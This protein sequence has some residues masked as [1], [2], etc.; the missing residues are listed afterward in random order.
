MSLEIGQ[1]VH[2][3]IGKQSYTISKVIGEGGQGTVYLLKNNYEMLALKWY[4][5]EQATLYLT[6][7]TIRPL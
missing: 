6:R 3:E 4:N 1:Q 2:S 7:S 5:Y